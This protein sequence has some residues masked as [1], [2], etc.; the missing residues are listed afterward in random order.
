MKLSRITWL[1]YGPQCVAV[2]GFLL[3]KVYPEDALSRYRPQHMTRED[4]GETP[5]DPLP[6]TLRDV[7]AF[8]DGWIA[9]LHGPL[10]Q[11]LG[12]PAEITRGLLRDLYE[13]V[14]ELRERPALPEGLRRPPRVRCSDLTAV[15]EVLR[16]Y[17]DWSLAALRPA[18]GLTTVAPPSAVA[19]PPPPPPPPRLTVDLA[20]K[21]ITLDGMTFDVPSD[22]ALRWVRV[23]AQRPGEWVSGPQLSERDPDLQY[24]RPDRFRRHLPGAVL[25]LIDSAP[26][27]G[28]RIRL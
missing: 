9:F 10:A 4:A 12:A 15:A 7:P 16:D 27:K 6:A 11:D 13:A 26:G 24:P 18:P 19:P 25:A 14:S 2:E 22:N 21:A 17:R 8:C 28:A 5:A 1:P 3:G 23:L 20:R